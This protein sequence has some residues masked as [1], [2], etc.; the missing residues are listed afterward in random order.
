L[1]ILENKT[2]SKSCE[3]SRIFT[4]KAHD[5]IG[6]GSNGVIETLC[7]KVQHIGRTLIIKRE[8]E[9]ENN[10]FKFQIGKSGLRNNIDRVELNICIL[11]CN[12]SLA[13]EKV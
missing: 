3:T 2:N 12:T 8:R 9:R 6:R 4:F 13:H 1:K 10:T 7:R 5:S 11:C